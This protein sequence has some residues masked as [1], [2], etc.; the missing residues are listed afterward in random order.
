[1]TTTTSAVR[2]TADVRESRH[3]IL[4]LV[5]LVATH[6]VVFVLTVVSIVFHQ[7][8]SI[9]AVVT[10]AVIVGQV[11]SG[12]GFAGIQGW[13]IV[14][15][16][17]VIG[18]SAGH[19]AEMW[20]AYDLAFRLLITIRLRVYDGVERT[21]PGGLQD[22]RTGDLASGALSDVE[23]LEW[24]YAHTIGNLLAAVLVPVAAL[25]VLGT[26]DPR[27]AFVLAPALLVVGT[28][29]FTLRRLADRQGA[30]LKERLATVHAEVVDGVQGLRELVAFGRGPAY[31][32]SLR[33]HS[34]A[35]YAEQLR[36]GHRSGLEAGIAEVAMALGIVAVLALGAQLLSA[37]RIPFADYPPAI[38]LAGYAFIPLLEVSVPLRMLG[39]IRASA[40]RVHAITD[41]PANVADTGRVEVLPAGSLDVR[42]D[43][44][45]FRYRVG[46][47]DALRGVSFTIPAGATV[48]LVGQS[49]SGK[50]TCANLLMRFWDPDHGAVLVGG[51]DSRTLPVDRLRDLVALVPQDV[52]L[53]NDSVRANIR[54][55]RTEA[56][57]AEVDAA[58]ARALVAE[59]VPELPD[60]LDT[61]IGERGATLSG[62]QRQ[63]IA[64][65][66]AL[67]K[68]APILVMDEAVSNLD[69]E[70]EQALNTAMAEARRGRTT[71]LIAHRL[72][73]IR[74][75]DLIVTLSD[76]QIAE[77]GSYQQLLAADGAFARLVAAQRG[78][79][80]ER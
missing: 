15:A 76:G 45:T 48:A 14:L 12:A 50:S 71:L 29:P 11:A 62:G 59:F 13:L 39:Q 60:G 61:V 75:A 34:R 36:F 66:R 56:S 7:V 55:G 24:F 25:V 58:V 65:A 64:I 2:P 10:G 4:R 38:V 43:A 1:M 69:T 19:W 32:R 79:S 46:D 53:F 40:A 72:S 16:L 77:T 35:L 22:R 3:P 26:V 23:T 47:P 18:R 74:S 51:I 9:G 68:N 63:R 70:N 78:G 27:L 49:G 73:T 67:L 80:L 17:L 57:D 31:V 21:A 8:C 6:P 42:F 37:G 44:V 41:A 54:L 28:A 30:R 20:I 33:R 52:Y 5:P